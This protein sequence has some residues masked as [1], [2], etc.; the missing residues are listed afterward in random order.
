MAYEFTHTV[1]EPLITLPRLSVDERVKNA[2]TSTEDIRGVRTAN[3]GTAN[4]KIGLGSPSS[5]GV[6]LDTIPDGVDTVKNEL[7]SLVHLKPKR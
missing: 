3:V 7:A 6:S 4:D 5:R 1:P 2:L